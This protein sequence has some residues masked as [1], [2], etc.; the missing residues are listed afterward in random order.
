MLLFM[1]L[2]GYCLWHWLVIVY[3]TGWLLFMALVGLLCCGFDLLIKGIIF[4]LFY[5]L[6]LQ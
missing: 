2:V 6:S 5:V 3:G 1:A 4:Y